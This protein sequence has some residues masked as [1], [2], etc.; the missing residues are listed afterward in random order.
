MREAGKAAWEMDGM[1]N[2]A[3]SQ[4]SSR[5]P[6]EWVCDT[7]NPHVPQGFTTQHRDLLHWELELVSQV[8]LLSQ[9]R[10]SVPW[11]LGPNLLQPKATSILCFCQYF[12]R[13]PVVYPKA[14]HILYTW[15]PHCFCLTSPTPPPSQIPSHLALYPLTLVSFILYSSIY[16]ARLPTPYT[17][18]T[19][20]AEVSALLLTL[21]YQLILWPLPSLIQALTSS[22]HSLPCSNFLLCP[23]KLT[24]S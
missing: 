15:A 16:L 18:A 7:F 11:A 1:E 9:G 17:R 4:A 13:L 20:P 8:P 19:S 12:Q 10:T 24:S 22:Q 23:T 5:W 3:C 6:N 21:R 14:F 2:W